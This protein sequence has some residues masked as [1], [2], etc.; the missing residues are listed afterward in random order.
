MNGW[1]TLIT[2]G[3]MLW[4]FALMD[5]DLSINPLLTRREMAALS[6]VG[7]VMMLVGLVAIACL[8]GW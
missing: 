6:L 8:V 3:Y 2:A 1:I 5:Q 7:L 4:L